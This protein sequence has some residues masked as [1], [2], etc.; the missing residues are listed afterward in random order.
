MTQKRMTIAQETTFE[1]DK[2]K[3]SRFIAY[4]YPLSAVS[5][6][7]QEVA[8]LWNTYPAAR[9]ICWAYRGAHQDQVRT[10]DDGEPSGTA[11]KPILSVIEGRDL[12][13]VGVAVVR[14]FGGTKLGTGGLARAYSSATQAVLK[15]C[16]KKYLRLRSRLTF[17]IHYSF[18][19]SLLY[20]LEQHE[21]MIKDKQYTDH[22]TIT[23]IVLSEYVEIIKSIMIDKTSGHVIIH[24]SAGQ[25][26]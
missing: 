3:G 1:I 24:Q 7:E 12:E 9:H 10:V 23:A 14:Y 8:K 22:V 5:F 26:L 2:I 13:S 21:A 15:A 18:E 25:W 20:L 19:A 17:R 16:Q 6:M 4:A 11:G